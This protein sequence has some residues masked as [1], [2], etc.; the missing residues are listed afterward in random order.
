RSLREKRIISSELDKIK[1]VGPKR[2][3]A[4]LDAF[5][6]VDGVSRASIDELASVNGIDVATAREIY[7]Y[8]NEMPSHDE[9]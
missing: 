2:R 8:F 3:K 5:R 4:L 7:R 9:T 6:D 1:G